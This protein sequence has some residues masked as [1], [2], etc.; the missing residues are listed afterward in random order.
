[1]KI[2]GTSY[3]RE[4][5]IDIGSTVKLIVDDVKNSVFRLAGGIEID[6]RDVV[7]RQWPMGRI[8]Y[9]TKPIVVPY[10]ICKCH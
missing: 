2:T 10:K 7:S 3:I 6:I 1:M 9:L 4:S 5:T 8:H